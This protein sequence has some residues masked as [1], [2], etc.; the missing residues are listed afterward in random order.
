[1]SLQACEHVICH[2]VPDTSGMLAAED[3]RQK[4]KLTIEDV[5][6]IQTMFGRSFP[7]HPELNHVSEEEIVL[8]IAEVSM[9]QIC[10]CAVQEEADRKLP[11]VR[12]RYA[13][14]ESDLSMIKMKTTRKPPYQAPTC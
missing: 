10:V 8:G 6:A 14:A 1:M 13:Q 2:K 5:L 9:L 12:D 7:L 4:L 11:A 3:A